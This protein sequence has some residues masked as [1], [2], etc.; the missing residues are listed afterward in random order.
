MTKVSEFSYPIL[1]A[2]HF[3]SHLPTNLLRPPKHSL[4][5]SQFENLWLI[6][7]CNWSVIRNDTICVG[8]S[9]TM[10]VI[11]AGVSYGPLVFPISQTAACSTCLAVLFIKAKSRDNVSVQ[12]QNVSTKMTQDNSG[13]TKWNPTQFLSSSCSR[14]QKKK[15]NLSL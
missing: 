2:L 8:F 6:E 12:S 1:C 5:D 11:T 3:F 7:R 4:V 10:R 9:Q 13:A 14:K 15:M